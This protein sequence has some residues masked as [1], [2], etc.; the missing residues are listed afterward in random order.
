MT[1]KRLHESS[2]RSVSASGSSQ[3]CSKGA[4]PA[5]QR[6]VRRADSPR[7]GSTKSP[8]KFQRAE[9]DELLLSV[10]PFFCVLTEHLVDER[11]NQ[12]IKNGSGPSLRTAVAKSMRSVLEAII[13]E[14]PEEDLTSP[15]MNQL[16]Q[17]KSASSLVTRML[18]FCVADFRTP[19]EVKGLL[20]ERT[21]LVT[22]AW[23][24]TC[25][26]EGQRI[27]T[28][29]PVRADAAECVDGDA[30]VS[31][32][33]NLS[34]LQLGVQVVYGPVGGP[35]AGAVTAEPARTFADALTNNQP[36]RGFIELTAEAIRRLS[37]ALGF[38]VDQCIP[39]YPDRNAPEY[40]NPVGRFY[41]L[42]APFKYC[43]AHSAIGNCHGAMRDA[44]IRAT[45]TFV[46]TNGKKCVVVFVD[47]T[48]ARHT[49]GVNERV[50]F[51]HAPVAAEESSAFR[52][53]SQE[54]LDPTEGAFICSAK[55]EVY[56]EVFRR[57]GVDFSLHPKKTFG[58]TRDVVTF[59]ARGA[60]EEHI[61]R[62]GGLMIPLRRIV[63]S[64]DPKKWCTLK[65]NN[66][67]TARTT[68]SQMI[69]AGL[70]VCK[71]FPGSR[72]FFCAYTIRVELGEVLTPDVVNSIRAVEPTVIASVHTDVRLGFGDN[73]RP[74]DIPQPITDLP[75]IPVEADR[76]LALY[77]R[78][79]SA[80]V[81][82][83]VVVKT[84]TEELGMKVLKGPGLFLED[85]HVVCKD[86]S[87]FREFRNKTILGGLYIFL[88]LGS[89]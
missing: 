70:S 69:A 13:K 82:A 3:Q 40:S 42:F 71:K 58:A 21:P 72:A 32:Q 27:T 54:E 41:A 8:S 68:P 18:E 26:L 16:C 87:Q 25:E 20:R 12:K 88:D 35:V 67:P 31:S 5:P 11:F 60:M 38:P 2:S 30:R 81:I 43:D 80:S 14:P 85:C 56:D 1:R 66:N 45:R 46:V 22:A 57:G 44:M 48:T 6:P 86:E 74:R 50:Q 89:K 65:F 61:T 15:R 7:A 52:V 37:E 78:C 36:R 19:G 59:A 73:T 76:P 75:P 34:P 49:G 9:H 4:S 28:S 51:L 10:Q 29:S 79:H 62:M 55:T 24:R 63:R 33:V 23:D 83:N 77:F 84:M 47:V 39:L 53:S 64:E 17:Y